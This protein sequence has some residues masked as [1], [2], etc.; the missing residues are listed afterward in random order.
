M[1]REGEPCACGGREVLMTSRPKKPNYCEDC[2]HHESVRHV[3]GD[4]M[5][6]VCL[7]SASETD[8]PGGVLR[9]DHGVVR[10][11]G[12]YVLECKRARLKMRDGYRCMKFS[13]KKTE[14]A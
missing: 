13:A 14:D 1:T 10:H 6:H 9:I 8:G 12:K 3:P 7:V 5:K 11:D 4:M 2:E